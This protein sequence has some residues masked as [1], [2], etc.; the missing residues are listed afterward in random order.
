MGREAAR[1]TVMP[2]AAHADFRTHLSVDA[3]AARLHDFL[4]ELL[5][6]AARAAT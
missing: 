3:A 2:E 5:V 1:R 4:S 6:P